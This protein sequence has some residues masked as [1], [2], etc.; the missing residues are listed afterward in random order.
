MQC[1]ATTTV[2]MTDDCLNNM[3]DLIETRDKTSDLTTTLRTEE[4]TNTTE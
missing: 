3:T 4:L 2:M 1:I